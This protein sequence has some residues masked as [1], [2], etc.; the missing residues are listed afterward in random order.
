M[1]KQPSNDHSDE[2]PLKFK[3]KF[4]IAST[5]I[6]DADKT[7]MPNFRNRGVGTMLHTLESCLN[8]NGNGLDQKGSS[9]CR[10]TPNDGM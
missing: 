7:S 1:E 6:S 10:N 5:V 3:T 8:L 2:L 4:A 9:M